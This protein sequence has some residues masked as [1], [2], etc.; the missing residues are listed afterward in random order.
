MRLPGGSDFFS[1]IISAIIRP[2]ELDKVVQLHFT[3]LFSDEFAFN[4]RGRSFSNT[5][6]NTQ[7]MPLSPALHLF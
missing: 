1:S 7:P 2:T 3:D 6:W 5:L 4:D